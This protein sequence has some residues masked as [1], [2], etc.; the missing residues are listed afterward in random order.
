MTWNHMR[1]TVRCIPFLQHQ[2]VHTIFAEMIGFEAEKL[3]RCVMK[4]KSS[5][6][7]NRLCVVELDQSP[8]GLSK[9]FT[10]LITCS[11]STKDEENFLSPSLGLIYPFSCKPIILGFVFLKIRIKNTPHFSNNL[12]KPGS[13]FPSPFLPVVGMCCFSLS[14]IPS[15]S[16]R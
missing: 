9:P 7:S 4:A 12:L 14:I 5:V 1:L 11:S 15:P 3:I 2:A 16:F 10:I 13:L 6:N 8:H